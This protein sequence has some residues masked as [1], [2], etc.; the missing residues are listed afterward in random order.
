MLT[1]YKPIIKYSSY[2]SAIKKKKVATILINTKLDIRVT[3]IKSAV[4]L[5][6]LSTSYNSTSI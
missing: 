2:P 4:N 6:K 5:V 1:F 3:S